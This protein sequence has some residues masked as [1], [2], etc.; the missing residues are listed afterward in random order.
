LKY[1]G[2]SF[3]TEDPPQSFHK[4]FQEDD[5]QED[6]IGSETSG[7]GNGYGGHESCANDRDKSSA[8]GGPMSRGGG[9]QG[10]SSVAGG[11]ARG[12]DDRRER[13]GFH[14]GRE[15]SVGVRGKSSEDGMG[16]RRANDRDEN[17]TCDGR[18]NS[19]GD[20]QKD[21][22]DDERKSSGDGR[23]KRSVGRQGYSS[24]AIMEQNREVGGGDSSADD[25][26]GN[27]GDN[28]HLNSADDGSKSNANGARNNRAGNGGE[29]SVIDKRESNDKRDTVHIPHDRG[30]RINRRHKRNTM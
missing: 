28:G 26:R 15:R 12:G 30:E 1:L 6:N 19:V 25:T 4:G 5:N 2:S 21:S 23:V 22:V 10:E 27:S 18:K 16:S 7:K 13:D 17:I 20:R 11:R 8:D 24:N 3:I 9:G 29:N 14:G